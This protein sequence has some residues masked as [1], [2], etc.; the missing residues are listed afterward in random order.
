[1]IFRVKGYEIQIDDEDAVRVLAQS[2][3]VS[4]SP[5]TDG[6]VICFSAKIGK[7]IIKLH[8]F[9]MG[10]PSGRVVDHRNGDRLDNR[11]ANL[12][13]CG[14]GEN[15]RN[16]GMSRSNTSGYKGVSFNKQR[17]KYRAYIRLKGGYQKHLGFF[18]DP[19]IAS[20]AYQSAAILYFGEYCRRQRI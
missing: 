9:I 11:K 17:G 6:H 1:M 14:I 12:R 3:W 2:W 4:S 16:R 18:D 15:N 13:I 10:N 7:K 5:E 20:L 8:R 19:L